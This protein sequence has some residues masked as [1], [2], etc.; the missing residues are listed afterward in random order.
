M[1]ARTIAI[2]LASFALA[3]PIHAEVTVTDG[4][5][6]VVNGGRIRL[7]EIDSPEAYQSCAV[8]WAAGVMATQA[9]R[10]LVRGHAVTCEPKT[11]DRFGRTVA[12][13]RA[14][15]VDLGAAMVRPGMAVAFTKFSQDLRFTG[16]IGSGRKARPPGTRWLHAAFGIPDP[17]APIARPPFRFCLGQCAVATATGLL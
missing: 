3:A 10:D 15:G 4:D 14:G 16:S 2:V 17:T 7:H 9:L 11:T 1:K 12:V 6:L 5:S 13:C 8:G